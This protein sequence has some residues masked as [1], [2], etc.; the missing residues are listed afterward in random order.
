MGDK[1]TPCRTNVSV[2]NR[3]RGRIHL[4]V[5][6]VCVCTCVLARVRVLTEVS[7]IEIHCARPR[8]EDHC[9]TSDVPLSKYF[10]PFVG[11]QSPLPCS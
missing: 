2:E 3:S 5:G 10:P 4:P 8:S 9:N 1:I 11:P 6:P 7:E